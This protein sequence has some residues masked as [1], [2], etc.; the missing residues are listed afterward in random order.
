VLAV[1]TACA[2]LFARVAPT[3]GWASLANKIAPVIVVAGLVAMLAGPTAY[4]L[5]TV[6]KTLSGG[7]PLAGPVSAEMGV[8]G[9][10][11]GAPGAGFGGRGL[12]AGSAPGIV[13]LRPP[14]GGPPSG[15]VPGGIPPVTGEAAAGSAPSLFGNGVRAGAGIGAGPGVGVSKALI[16]YLKAHQ[17][18][19]TYLVAAVGSSSAG[20][21][22]L[23]SGRNVINM[24]GFMGS[25]PAP[26]LA[27]L[28]SFIASG[29]LHYVLLTGSG[30]S[31][32]A[33]GALRGSGLGGTVSAL[34][35]R[36]IGTPGGRTGGPGAS[37][38]V[39]T[40]KAISERDAWVE[41]H[42][43]VV[44]VS[45]ESSTAGGMTLYHFSRR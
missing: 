3:V 27:K 42:G 15:G 2:L 30:G 44:H 34:G 43:T 17:G 24:G 35:G 1:L 9:P 26:S 14:G 45:G 37:T 23:E 10:G 5:A 12:R 4:S 32:G 7:D 11:G 13:G 16:S 21:I 33:V 38:S 25:D 41:A 19:A 8:G 20:P 18:K 29:Q 31:G 28:K 40:S 22:A 6:G 39:A 36:G